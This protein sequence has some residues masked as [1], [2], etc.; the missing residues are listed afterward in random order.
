M[1]WYSKISNIKGADATEGGRAKER[2]KG[3]K[4]IEHFKK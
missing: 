3:D 1:K 4:V 2:I